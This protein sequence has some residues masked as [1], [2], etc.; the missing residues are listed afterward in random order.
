MATE[1][2]LRNKYVKTA[3]AYLGVKGGSAKH[4]VIID[5]FNK[6]K[7]DGWAMTYSAAWC[8]TFASACAIE[9]FGV[10][11]AKKYFPLSANCGTIVNKAKSMGIWVENDGYMPEIG[12]LIVY[13]WQDSGAGDNTGVPDHIGIVEKIKN[14]VITVIEGNKNDKVDRRTVTVN[15]RYIRGFVTPKY[16]KMAGSTKEY[17]TVKKGD[18]LSGIAK[19]YNTTVKKLVS[20]NKI[21]NANL[22]YPGQKLRV[23]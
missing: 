15:G 6:I 19:K 4:K 2:S 22:I 11:K 12:D 14:G 20:L 16:N 17:Y 18:T 23:K 21:K 9:A 8:A 10:D 1:K 13:D 3:K 7:P 5:T